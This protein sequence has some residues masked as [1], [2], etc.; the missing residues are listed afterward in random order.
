MP[1]LPRGPALRQ[2]PAVS[3][4]ANAISEGRGA[5]AARLHKADVGN[6]DDGYIAFFVETRHGKS[7]EPQNLLDFGQACGYLD[8]GIRRGV[9]V[10]VVLER[11]QF[12]IVYGLVGKVHAHF[13]DSS[14]RPNQPVPMPEGW[15]ERQRPDRFDLQVVQFSELLNARERD[16]VCRDRASHVDHG[17]GKTGAI[18]CVVLNLQPPSKE[19]WQDEEHGKNNDGAQNNSIGNR[20]ASNWGTRKIAVSVKSTMKMRSQAGRDHSSGDQIMVPK[21]VT[22]SSTMWLRM[23]A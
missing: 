14:R 2:N 8:V 4:K 12:P 10:I 17:R 9:G 20:R 23:P 7:R 19:C 16:M 6:L 5:V 15:R 11:E 13:V 18:P 3:A 1:V 21:E 22:K